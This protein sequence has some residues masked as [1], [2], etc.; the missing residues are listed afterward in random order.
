MSRL[1]NAALVALLDAIVSALQ[2]IADELRTRQDY[3]AETRD[4]EDRC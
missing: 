1:T 4:Y 3:D 2:R